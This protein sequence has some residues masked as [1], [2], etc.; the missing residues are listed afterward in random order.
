MEE[1]PAGTNWIADRRLKR[2]YPVSCAAVPAVPRPDRLY[3]ATESAVRQ[4]GYSSSPACGGDQTAQLADA[5]PRLQAVPSESLTCHRLMPW[6][7]ACG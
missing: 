1:A 3:Y 7:V 4:D 2:Y 6:S 5:P